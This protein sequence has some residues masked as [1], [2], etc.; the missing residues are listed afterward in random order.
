MISLIG[1]LI[2]LALALAFEIMTRRSERR[3]GDVL[4]GLKQRCD[5][6]HDAVKKN[7]G[8]KKRRTR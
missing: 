2:L 7:G 6:L 5:S 1:T 8:L 3:Q 4:N